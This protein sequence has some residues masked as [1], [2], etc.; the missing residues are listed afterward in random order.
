MVTTSFPRFAGDPA[1]G[2]VAEHV[3]W[4][5]RAG[6]QVD[7]VCA[8]WG[9]E[10]GS[11]AMAGVTVERV[12]SRGLFY[13]G[14]APDALAGGAGA[15]PRAAAFQVRLA[16]AVRRRCARWDAVIAH[17]LVPS[18]MAAVAARRPMVAV[19][20]SG[21][22]HMLRALGM[23]TPVA[24]AL[25]GAR[26]RVVFVS[27]GLRARFLASVRCAA[28]ARAVYARSEVS[29]MGVDVNRLARA[30]AALG[31]GGR[32]TAAFVGR[33][34]PIKGA[35]V[36]VAATALA[37][38]PV[39]LTVAGGGPEAARVA[40]L[41]ARLCPDRAA[42]VGEVRGVGRDATLAGATLALVPSL[43]A[44][45]GR[46]EGMPVVALEAM[47]AGAA[48]IAS[49][50]GGLDELPGDAVTR[51]PPGDPRALAAAMDALL[52]DGER[53]RR[54][55]AAASAFVRARDWSRVGPR[56]VPAAE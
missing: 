17:W 14:G 36:A 56:L 45:G 31:H 41:I 4:L 12:C 52:D 6:H 43:M 54:Q 35:R 29:P 42:V 46:T 51:V 30:R 33:L 32:A 9:Q 22:V 53:R 28:V 47:A 34:V 5:V 21:D 23:A 26:A 50:V 44:G 2:F 40:D 48:V 20:H 39:T 25:V 16:A 49:R 1:G 27:E 11:W 18:A 8:G 38:A 3:T 37:R 19:A 24:A 13:E 55:V 10:S 15:W 7:V